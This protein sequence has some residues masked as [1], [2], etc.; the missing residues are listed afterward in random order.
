[1][2]GPETP[3]EAGI[4]AGVIGLTCGVS[5][6]LSALE[7]FMESERFVILVVAFVMAIVVT[8]AAWRVSYLVLCKLWDIKR[9][10]EA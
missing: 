8:I 3:E 10:D 6:L 5:F 9:D 7:G 1:M 2:T 4:I